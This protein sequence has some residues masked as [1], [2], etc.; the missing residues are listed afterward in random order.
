MIFRAAV[1][2]LLALSH[3]AVN[4]QPAQPP[5]RPAQS[6]R[7]PNQ[8][9][10]HLDKTFPGWEYLITSGACSSHLRK[11]VITGYFN[12]DNIEDYII[13]IEYN[14]K[15]IV[16]GF[17]SSG[18][19]GYKPTESIIKNATSAV[20]STGFGFANTGRTV[21]TEQG[22]RVKLVNDALISWPCPNNRQYT[23]WV[24]KNGGFNSL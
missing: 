19:G 15:G 24:Y 21:I 22:K 4:G 13:K 10:A 9:K 14:S 18:E 3:S 2:C 12:G 17:V 5:S 23:Y 1:A 7:L 20:K 11:A 8:I 16:L 6:K